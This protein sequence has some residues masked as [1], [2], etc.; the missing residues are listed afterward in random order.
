MSPFS[1]GSSP[2]ISRCFFQ[3]VAAPPGPGLVRSIIRLRCFPTVEF[4]PRGEV[5]PRPSEGVIPT[6]VYG[7]GGKWASCL[8]FSS[9]LRSPRG[10]EPHKCTTLS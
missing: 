4:P 10:Q 1:V 7:G 9:L 3:R 8:R 6:T 2:R 5:L